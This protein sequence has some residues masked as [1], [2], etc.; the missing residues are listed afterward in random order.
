M[1]AANIGLAWY[2]CREEHHHE[3]DA[4]SEV[5]LP[6]LARCARTWIIGKASFASYYRRAVR[7]EFGKWK[8]RRILRATAE[9][10]ESQLKGPIPKVLT[11]HTPLNELI[12]RERQMIANA[13][14][15]AL[16]NVNP[17]ACAA[18]SMQL[19]EGETRE[20]TAEALGLTIHVVRYITEK[21]IRFLRKYSGVTT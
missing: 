9:Q 20:A 19:M 18:I 17:M 8:K 12:A 10:S 13:A 7:G 21:G 3:D 14:I 11:Y 16:W 15:E 6:V 2:V 4:F 5:A 1:V